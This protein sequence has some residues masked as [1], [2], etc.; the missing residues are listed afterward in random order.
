MMKL[1]VKNRILTGIIN[2]FLIVLISCNST[3][4]EST[5]KADTKNQKIMLALL[6]DTSNSMDGLIDQAKSQL[7]TI[8]NELAVAKCHDGARPEIKIAL[9]EYGNSRLPSSEGYIRMVTNLTDDLDEISEKLFSLKTNGGDE[10]CGQVIKRSIDQLEWSESD[11]DLKMIFIAG[12]EPFTQGNYPYRS[13]CKLSKEKGIIVNTIFCGDYDNGIRSFWK[14][15]ASITG[16]SYMAIQQDR[17]TVYIDTPYD[18]KIDKLN[19]DLNNTYIYYG[20]KGVAKKE[21][22]IAQDRNAASYSQA[23]KVKRAIS[24]SSHAYKNKS[25]DLVDA[26]EEDEE[27]IA[28]VAEESLPTEMKGM[29]TPQRKSY[30]KKQAEARK[31]IQQEIQKLSTKRKQFIADNQPKG[32]KE[33]TLDHAMMKSIKEVAKTKQLKFE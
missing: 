18:K 32:N 22:Q 4:S 7:W 24:K 16:G 17:K 20:N 5:E 13:A 26:A 25:W 21:M 28:E 15:G 8:V 2:T 11:A 9:F 14:E 1:L 23:N 29:N 12:N 27:A 10:F 19:D 33:G 3:Y 30:V 31:D 6:L